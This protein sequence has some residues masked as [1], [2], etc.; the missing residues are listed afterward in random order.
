MFIYEKQIG[1]LDLKLKMQKL[2]AND[3]RYIRILS[4]R[5]KHNIVEYTL[6]ETPKLK[7]S[8]TCLQGY[9]MVL[10]DYICLTVYQWAF[11]TFNTNIVQSHITNNKISPSCR[12]FYHINRVY[13]VQSSLATSA[14]QEQEKSVVDMAGR[15]YGSKQIIFLVIILVFCAKENYYIV[16]KNDILFKNKC[17][18]LF[19]VIRFL[20][21]LCLFHY[22]DVR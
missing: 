1:G 12:S 17:Y 20:T 18:C 3:I 6:L 5:Y 15:T 10:L 14:S 21:A 11:F 7:H 13:N 9:N 2:Q 4:P 22:L 8:R 16:R 19:Q